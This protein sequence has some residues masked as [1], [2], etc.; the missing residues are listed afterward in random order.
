MNYTY[1][2]QLWKCVCVCV[3][4]CVTDSYWRRVALSVMCHTWVSFCVATY[5]A[6]D[7]YRLPNTARYM[8]CIGLSVYSCSDIIKHRRTRH[9][10]TA[11]LALVFRLVV[12]KCLA[13]LCL[14]MYSKQ[15]DLRVPCLCVV[16]WPV[17]VW[18]SSMFQSHPRVIAAAHK[19]LDTHGAGLSSVRFICGTQVW[20]LS[21]TCHCHWWVVVV[22][23]AL[24]AV[25]PAPKC[26]T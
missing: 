22:S 4:V 14:Y 23:Q 17:D 12:S 5:I 19:A 20:C 24:H 13:L 7:M 2:L 15:V 25:L 18:L 1:A 10:E 11:M 8:A 3:C 21:F 6:Y 16:R 26:C 9:W